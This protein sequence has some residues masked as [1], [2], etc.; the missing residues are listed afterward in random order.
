MQIAIN[1]KDNNTFASA[2][3]DTTVKV[4]L[5]LPKFVK[6][7]Q[8]ELTNIGLNGH[9]ISV[10]QIHIYL[11]TPIHTAS[12]NFTFSSTIVSQKMKLTIPSFKTIYIYLLST[13]LSKI[14]F[15]VKVNI[16]VPIYIPIG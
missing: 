11:L 5:L 4:N 1:P 15:N 13:L 3:L 16:N 6:I 9:L 8:I 12:F 2:S 14:K 10:T 7:N